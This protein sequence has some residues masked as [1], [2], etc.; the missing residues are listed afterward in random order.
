MN[1]FYE[2]NGKW[3]WEVKAKNGKVL[4]VS[5]NTGYKRKHDCIKAFH[6]AKSIMC[7]GLIAE[8]C[9]VKGA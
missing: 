3:H 2:K 9:V 6:K 5:R 7:H 4:A 1:E 8:G